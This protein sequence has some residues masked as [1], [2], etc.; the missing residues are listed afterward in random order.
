MRIVPQRPLW[1]RAVNRLTHRHGIKLFPVAF[2][3]SLEEAGRAPA[4]V[5]DAVYEKNY[6]QDDES[7]SGSGSTIDATRPYADSLIKNLTALGIQTLFDAPCGDLNWIGRV[8]DETGVDYSGG[9]IATE[10]VAL[11]KS[12]RPDLNIRRFDICTDRFPDCDLWHCRDTFFHLSFTDIRRALVNVSKSNIEFAALTTH[13][14]RVLTNLDIKT[15]GFRL[16]DLERHPFSFPTPTALLE[17][18]QTGDFPR[19][20]GI[21]KVS[22]LDLGRFAD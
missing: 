13:R 7:K 19:Y 6:W 5:F 20:V 8:I 17:D 2:E 9:D 11:A 3:S 1:Q 18:F 4:E 15:G 21:W 16:L 12:R 10:A 22:D 14:A